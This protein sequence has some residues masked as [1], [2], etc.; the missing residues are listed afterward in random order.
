MPT[1]Q[2][3]LDKRKNIDPV[4]GKNRGRA[5][6][7]QPPKFSSPELMQQAIDSF[8]TACDDNDDPYTISGLAL[9]LDMD[10][11]TL[12]NYQQKD[13]Y[14]ATIKKAK[15]RCQTYAER[16]GWTGNPAFACF[17]LKNYGWSDRQEQNV[18]V[19]GT[20][21]VE[22]VSFKPAP[23]KVKVKKGK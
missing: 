17:V 7:G 3:A 4:T 12:L 1:N 6:L 16:R 8:F 18:S 9:A 2:A 21:A 14:V 13:A 10:T 11:Q 23:V 19:S 5:G 22:V 20:M 15:Q